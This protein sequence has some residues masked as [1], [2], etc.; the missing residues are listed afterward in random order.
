M[1]PAWTED[2]V[3]IPHV[4]RGRSKDGCDCLG[5][6]ILVSRA[7]RGVE[8]PDPYCSM[9][10]A[11]R[12][13]VAGQSKWLYDAVTEPR[14][15]DA[16]LIRARGHPVHVGYCIDAHTMLHSED[17]AGSVVEPFIGTKWK[18]RV[19]G[20]YRYAGRAD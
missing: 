18:H 4:K 10:R 7:R 13:D 11:I 19:M 8:I 5:L 16:V 17:G 9:T 20:I 6:F 3:G 12:S 15:G 14:E 2:W 1:V